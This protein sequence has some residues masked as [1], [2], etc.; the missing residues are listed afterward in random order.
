MGTPIKLSANFTL[1]E[2]TYSET[3]ARAGVKN[4]PTIPAFISLQ[5]LAATMEIVR[6]VCGSNPVT[7]TSGYRNAETNA[8]VGGSTNSAHLYGLGA[9]FI[10]PCYGDPLDVCL[11][12]Q[13]YVGLL[14]IDQLIWEYGDWV[15]L[16]LVAHGAAPRGECLTIDERGMRVGF[17]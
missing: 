7:I 3:A 8:L 5:K 13:P 17:A 2:F 9:D 11:A 16:G 12:I 6:F 15:H 1:A 4:V 14:R 10:I